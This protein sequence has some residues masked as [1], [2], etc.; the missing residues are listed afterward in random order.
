MKNRTRAVALLLSLLLLTGCTNNP[1]IT[2]V[3]S[4]EPVSTTQSEAA[5]TTATEEIVPTNASTAESETSE[6]TLPSSDEAVSTEE[7]SRKAAEEESRRAAEEESRKAAEEESRR[8]A[9]EERKRAEEERIRKE[10]LNS[11]SMMYY[12]A[13]TAEEIR[14]SKDNRVMLDDIYTSLLN[15]IN[16]GAIDEITQDHLKNLR[17]IIKTFIN[18]STKRERLQFIYNQNKAAAMRSAVPN[19]I[20]ILSMTRSLDWKK[21][22]LSAVYSVVDSYTSYK[23]ASVSADTEFLMSGWE[24]DDEE[25]AAVQKNRDRAFDYM[26]DMVQE[27]HL[28]GLLT[29][30]E[31][32][33]EKFAEICAIESVPEKIRRLVSEEGTYQLLGNYWLELADCYFETSQYEKCLACVDKYNELYTGIYRQ[34]TNYAKILPKA[35]VAAQ[36]VYSGEQYTIQISAFA[37]DIMKNTSTDNWSARYFVA[38]VYIDLYNR[39]KGQTYLQKAYDIAYSNVVILLDGQRNLNTTYLNDVKEV[40]AEEPDYRFLSDKEKKE[41]EQ[42]FKD[43]KKRVKNYNNALNETRKTELP[44][45]YEPLVLNCEL[46]FA[47]AEKMNISMAEK[48]EIESILQTASNGIFMSKPIN[49]AY[50]FYGKDERYSFE[51][52]KSEIIIPA[53]LLTANVTIGANIKEGN[54]GVAFFDFKV[55]KV[56]RKGDSID[57]FFAHLTSSTWKDY[58]WT[59]NSKITIS[60]TYNDAY[61]KQIVLSYRVSKYKKNVLGIVQVEFAQE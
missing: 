61:D 20:A 11:F 7:E 46:L 27:Y 43:E 44:T 54:S 60:I 1:G 39:T 22:A 35:I 34:D 14:I 9:E 33:V 16:P 19:P 51:L 48:N 23:N 58:K 45:L 5:Q 6:P 12:L 31:K 4:E 8:A 53:D 55:T 29:L 41:K 18:V 10:Q 25:L 24:L 59:E 3:P 2:Q 47:L 56:E 17:D 32:A 37:D 42:E 57:T 13:I 26:V 50:S 49:N 30:N 52:S 38:Q 15:D 36:N 21:L 40:V 28:D